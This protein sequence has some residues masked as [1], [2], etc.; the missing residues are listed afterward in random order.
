MQFARRAAILGLFA[1][2]S[3]IS[4][5][6]PLAAQDA[7]VLTQPVLSDAQQERFCS[8]PRS[9]GPETSTRASQGPGAQR[10]LTDN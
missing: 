6:V 3:V 5:A 4:S 1:F 10:C 2:V 8:R 9:S 7:A